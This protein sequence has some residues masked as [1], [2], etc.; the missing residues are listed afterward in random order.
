MRELTYDQLE[1]VS[2]GSVKDVIKWVGD[3]WNSYAEMNAKVYQRNAEIQYEIV[4]SPGYAEFQ[5]SMILAGGV[6]VGMVLG[7]GVGY[8]VALLI[9]GVGTATYYYLIQQPC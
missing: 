2:G 9:I 4:S 3:K 6:A 5:S 7:F 1:M 8:G